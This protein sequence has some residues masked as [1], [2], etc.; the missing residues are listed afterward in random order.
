MNW[1]SGTLLITYDTGDTHK[2]DNV[3]YH[4]AIQIVKN[5]TKTNLLESAVYIPDSVTINV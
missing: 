1:L 3:T 2:E 4:Q 5:E